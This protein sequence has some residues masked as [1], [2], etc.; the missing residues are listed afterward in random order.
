MSIDIMIDLETCGIRAGCTVLSIGA[1]S[2]NQ[3]HSFYNKID[4]ISS[5]ERGLIEDPS[6][7]QWWDRQKP[8]ARIEAFSGTRTVEQ[9]LG[10]F[11]DWLR[12]I[13]KKEDIFVWGNGADF[14]LP[15][16]A[17]VYA[18]VGMDLPWAPFNGRCY[19]TLKNLYKDVKAPIFE[20]M[21]HNA[22]YDAR[23]QAQHAY[24]ILKKHFR[25][26]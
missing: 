16:L 25:T 21:K 1:S 4:P 11:S 8:E 18:K 15:I 26:E 6:T 9:A 7:M 5:K 3:V 19:R 10:E 23:Y 14:D 24:M 12:G 17:A 13:G 2:F 22:L 20:G